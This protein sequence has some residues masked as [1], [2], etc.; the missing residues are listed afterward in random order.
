[1]N[2]FATGGETFMINF[3]LKHDVMFYNQNNA[4]IHKNQFEMIVK[5]FWQSASFCINLVAN[6]KKS[7]RPV[8]TPKVRRCHNLTFHDL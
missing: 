5:T 2:D 7:D 6:P 3:D 1:M 8:I 4:F